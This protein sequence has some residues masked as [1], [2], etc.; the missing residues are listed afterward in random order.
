MPDAQSRSTGTR[1]LKTAITFMLAIL[2]MAALPVGLMAADPTETG[3]ATA[4]AGPTMTPAEAACES[5]DDLRLIVGF[6]QDI[7]I[8][9]DG[10]LPVFVGA[11]AGLSE[12]RDLMGHVGETYRPLVD[13]LI[14]SLEDVRSTVSLLGELETTGAQVAAI[15]EAIT[16]IGNAMD[17]LSIQLGTPCPTE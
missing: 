1:G 13:D 10:W 6:L 4:S 16:D 8:E 7:D 14:G 2:L 3:D 17:A 15:G 12:A 9:N 11:V 5:V